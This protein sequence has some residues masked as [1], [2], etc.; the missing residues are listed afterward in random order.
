LIFIVNN[1]VLE[2]TYNMEFISK[3]KIIISVEGNIGVGKSTFIKILESKWKDC[4]VVSEPVDMWKEIVDNEGKNI[5]QTFYEN[6]PRWAYSFQNIACITR[7][8]KIEEAI[9][10]S[11][12]KYIFLDRSLGTDKNVFEAML[13][14]QGQ[15]NKIEHSMYN[16]W[17]DFYHKYVR[18][19]DNQIY[20]YLKA[21]PETCSDRIKKRGR[22]EEESIELEY[23]KGLDKYHNDWL[24][25]GTQS[26]V[27]VIDCEEEF[28]SD[29]QKHFQMIEQIKQKLIE[30]SSNL[31]LD[32]LKL[33]NIKLNKCEK[34]AKLVNNKISIIQDNNKRVNEEYLPNDI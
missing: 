30:I 13:Y 4:E 18:S 21:S 33:E 15:I 2:N 12:A 20:I 22:V 10:N 23:L 32:N 34:D 29:E 26:N 25:N 24:V 3:Q 11:K 17:C 16:L 7:M 6:I 14:D 27:I 19:Q 9:R 8:M 1:Y 5:L 28:E 31:K